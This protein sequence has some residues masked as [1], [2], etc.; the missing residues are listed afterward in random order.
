MLL[1]LLSVICL[2]IQSTASLPPSGYYPNGQMS[3]EIDPVKNRL[4]LLVDGLPYKTY[5]IALGKPETPSPVGNFCIVNKSRNWG[6]GF[7]TRWMGLNVTWGIYGI[8][9]TNK[10]HSI[11][12][13][14]SHGCVRMLNKHV[15]ELYDIVPIGT[16]VII[17][18]HVLG[19]LHQ[20]PKPLAKG[21]SGALVKLMQNRLKAAGYYTGQVHGKFDGATEWA[22]RKYEK[23]QGLPVDGVLGHHDYCSLGIWE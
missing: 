22:L 13:D 6:S 16:P 20:E 9:G 2:P 18:G 3:I 11:G 23:A 10:P 5:P 12:T 14:A 7:G 15:E 19:E 8:H 1:I 21:D 4:T 17:L